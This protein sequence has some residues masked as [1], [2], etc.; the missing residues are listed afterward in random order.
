MVNVA[1]FETAH[2][3]YDGI[4]FADMTEELIAKTFAR[5]RALHESGNID[6]LNRSRDDFLRVRYLGESRQPR[7]GHRHDADVGID[8]TERIIFRRC[9]MRACQRVKKRGLPDVRQPHNPRA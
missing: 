2:D 4:Y 6:E 7:I 5:T 1:T 3:L 9:L 8:R